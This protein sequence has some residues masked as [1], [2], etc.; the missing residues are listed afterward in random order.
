MTRQSSFLDPLWKIQTHFED[1]S[2]GDEL[3][4][5]WR[6]KVGGKTRKQGDEDARHSG[7][8]RLTLSDNSSWKEERKTRGSVKPG[9]GRRREG[10]RLTSYEDELNDVEMEGKKEDQRRTR[11]AEGRRKRRRVDSPGRW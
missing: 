4:L 11:R 5:N 3:G 6:S 1:I 8:T 10:A 9:S 7:R 2:I